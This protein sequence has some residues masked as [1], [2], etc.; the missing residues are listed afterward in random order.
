MTASSSR[1]F[2]K[3]YAAAPAVLRKTFDKQVGL[4]LENLNHPSLHAKKYEESLDLWQA[5]VKPRIELSSGSLLYPLS[6][7]EIAWVGDSRGAR[8]CAMLK[9]ACIP[10]QLPIARSCAFWWSAFRRCWHC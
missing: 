6:A 5:R 2:L 9:M 7:G 10:I 1:R 3:Q 4:L 8:V